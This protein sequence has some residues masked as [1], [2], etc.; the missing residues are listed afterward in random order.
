MRAYKQTK[1]VIQT[2]L[3]EQLVPG[4]SYAL[5]DGPEVDCEVKGDAQWWPEHELLKPHMLYDLAS[6]TKV[7]GTTTAVMQLVESQQISVDDKL[8]HYV[9]EWH[10]DRVS[11]RDLLTHTSAI[12][13]YIPTRTHPPAD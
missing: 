3:D 2:L 13:G 4:V 1:R 7:V 5:I 9:P 12:A 11:L 8:S 6:L 10:D